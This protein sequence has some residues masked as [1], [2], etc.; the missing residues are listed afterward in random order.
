MDYIL[1]P[2]GYARFENS[3][4]KALDYQKSKEVAPAPPASAVLKPSGDLFLKGD[5]KTTLT[6]I[7]L[8]DIYY[9][10]GM[11]NYAGFHTK[12]GLV[13]AL[14]T[15]RDLEERLP[16]PQFLRVHKSF[17]VAY[18]QVAAIDGNDIVIKTEKKEVRVPIGCN[19]RE[20]F[21]KLIQGQ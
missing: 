14:I 21:L 11:G 16:H 9:V 6:R 15:F 19:Y 10:E 17:I 8:E 5:T 20:R 18:D 1:K 4:Q 2:F 3:V 12:N 13:M 7:R